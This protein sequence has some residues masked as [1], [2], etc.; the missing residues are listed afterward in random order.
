MEQ[1]VKNIFKYV[2]GLVDASKAKLRKDTYDEMSLY[3]SVKASIETIV[4]TATEM[5]LFAKGIYFLG[6][7]DS[8][9]VFRRFAC[10]IY[11]VSQ[12]WAKKKL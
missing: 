1:L 9:F 5:P 12:V 6:C 7:N 10:T 11:S 3:Y 4:K 2:V 8:G